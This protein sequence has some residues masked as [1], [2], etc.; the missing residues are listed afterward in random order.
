LFALAL[1]SKPMVVTLPFVMLLL[2][3]WP[4]RRSKEGRI[5]KGEGKKTGWAW[6]LLEKVPFFALAG[7][8]CWLTL[9]A[10]EAA[11]VS[12]GALPVW[13]RITH[14]IAAYGHYLFAAFVP[15]HLAVMYPYVAKLSAARVVV[16][17]IVLAGISGV[18]VK[19]GKSRPWL[20]VGWLWF[21]GTLVP[22]IGLV[23]VGDQAWADR[24]TYL[25]L[26]GVFISV[27]W[28][29]ARKLQTPSSKLQKS[30]NTQAPSFGGRNLH[31]F[32]LGFAGIL[33][34]AALL[35]AS[36]VQLSYWRDTRTLFEHAAK[37]T[38]RN[39][40]A[41]TLL[42]SL[43]AKEGKFEEAI[44]HYRQALEWEPNYAEA[45]FFVGHALD[46]QGKLDAAIV[47]YSKALWYK[48]TQEQAHIYLGVALA[49]QNKTLEAASQ[50]EAALKIN[51][52]SAQA[53][54]NLA[55]L[56]HL[57]GRLDEAANHY[58]AALKLDRGLAQAHNNFGILLLEKGKPA[59]STTE[60]RE[61]LRLN[62]NDLETEYNL[63]LALNQQEQWKEAAELFGRT[64]RSDTK[65]SNAHYHYATALTHLG[66]T[67]E[68]LSEYASALLIQPDFPEALDGI[69]WVLATAANA[70]FRNGPE[71]MRMAERAC[72]LTGHKDARKLKTLAAA[73]AE[74]G[75][76]AQALATVRQAQQ[77][78]AAA[79]Q[80]S[81]ASECRLMEESFARNKPWRQAD[82]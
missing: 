79:G 49:K 28:E 51:P 65:D 37:V 7:A 6:L 56:L 4:L 26:V 31:R 12:T 25:P 38:E 42:G 52:E 45:H 8:S 82:P 39:Y 46:Q 81:L 48:P 62:P 32:A 9:G 72:E 74:A 36:S 40:M 14:A 44:E 55:K 16:S 29:I 27:V 64:V 21:L 22:V 1:M 70:Q 17:G 15:S 75:Q 78:A 20:L 5:E 30:F 63:A 53:H 77:M 34:C 57:Q 18:A 69:S 60:L 67:K 50:Y 33:L 23:Q 61:A 66:R 68:A 73:D 3:Y 59:E 76:F 58:R 19:F 41:V 47:E 10:Q 2:D 80:Q 35:T 13:N 43:L 54:N 11:M 24:Y 71:A